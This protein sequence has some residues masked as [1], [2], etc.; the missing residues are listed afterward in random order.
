MRLKLLF[1]IMR[2]IKKTMNKYN[3]KQMFKIKV[4]LMDEEALLVSIEIPK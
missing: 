2:S 1:R 3:N 4:K